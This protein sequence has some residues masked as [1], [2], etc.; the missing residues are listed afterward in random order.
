MTVLE[1]W[2]DIIADGGWN[3]LLM[4]GFLVLC[5]ML[6]LTVITNKYAWGVFIVV[7]AVLI[8]ARYTGYI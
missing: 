7:A 2:F 1:N 8:G 3:G 6:L 5:V 4:G